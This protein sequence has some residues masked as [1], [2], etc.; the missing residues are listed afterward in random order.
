MIS[1]IGRNCSSLI[2]VLPLLLFFQT[3]SKCHAFEI[4]IDV[5]PN[6]LN[7]Q[8]E[9]Q[10][11][12]VHTSIAFWDVDHSSVSL[13]DIEISSWKADNR[14]NFVAKFLM[15]QVKA[16]ADSGGLNVPGDNDLILEGST[17]DGA[18]FTGL[19]TITVIDI[20]AASAGGK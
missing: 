1:I 9:G 12:T 6:T 11:V 17:K 8:S 13:N 16:L 3:P 7:I 18:D 4:S 5:A 20:A 19:D 10:V 15:S 14:G 2:F